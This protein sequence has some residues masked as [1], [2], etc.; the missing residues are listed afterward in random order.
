MFIGMGR[1]GRGEQRRG[2]TDW[3]GKALFNQVR[4]GTAQGQSRCVCRGSADS[5]WAVAQ[6]SACPL[7]LYRS[8]MGVAQH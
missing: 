6:P 4:D 3:C 7:T 1:A 5:G 2:E 8:E